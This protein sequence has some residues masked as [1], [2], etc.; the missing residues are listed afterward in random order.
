MPR[1][2]KRNVENSDQVKPSSRKT[3]AKKEILW[4][5][6]INIRMD[7]H[8]K[9]LFEE[10]LSNDSVDVRVAVQDALAAGLKYGV[11]YDQANECFIASYTGSGVT[12]D[13]A[14]YC[15]TARAGTF[16]EATALL[17]FKD[18]VICGSDWGNYRPSDS[19]VLNWG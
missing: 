16:D 6:F 1:Q 4:G 10:W 2:T 19:S 13:N 8:S 14:R 11:S 3:N 15:L 17:V 7:D 5:G 18:L 12:G 9:H